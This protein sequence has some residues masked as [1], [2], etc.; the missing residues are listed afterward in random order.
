MCVIEYVCVFLIGRED[1]EDKCEF[2]LWSHLSLS[3]LLT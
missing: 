2:C 3:A 1:E